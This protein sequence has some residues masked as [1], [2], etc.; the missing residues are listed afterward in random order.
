MGWGRILVVLQA[1]GTGAV[2]RPGEGES[3]AMALDAKELSCLIDTAR[4]EKKLSRKEIS[5]RQFV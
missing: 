5:E 1:S 3:G 4:L 2:P